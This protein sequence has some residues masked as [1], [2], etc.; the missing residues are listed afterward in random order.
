M[1]LDPKLQN[2]LRTAVQT[3][4]ESLTA[5]HPEATMSPDAI[6][7]L[8]NDIVKD[9]PALEA[10]QPLMP[11]WIR[12]FIGYVGAFLTTRG[13]IESSLYEAIAGAVIM[14]APP[15]YRTI[16]TRVRRRSA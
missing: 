13:V 7:E 9:F 2:A 15:I 3:K 16:M 8:T 14:L 11:Q 12:Y 10:F 4:L 5:S 1:Y 6:Q